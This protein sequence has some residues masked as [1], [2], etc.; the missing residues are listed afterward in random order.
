MKYSLCEFEYGYTGKF[1]QVI[2]NGE[3]SFLNLDGSKLDL[4]PP[5]G[6]DIIEDDV[7]SPILL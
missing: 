2:E 1:Y 3:V 4:I 6:Y 5:Y 7:V